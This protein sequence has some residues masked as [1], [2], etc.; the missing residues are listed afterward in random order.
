MIE[1]QLPLKTPP[2]TA[3][4]ARGF[5]LIELMIAVAVLSILV[6]VALPTFNDSIRKG[7]RTEAFTALSQVQQAQERWRANNANYASNAQLTLPVT[8]ASVG[9]P[10]GLGLSST[11]SGE[12][13]GISIANNDATGYEVLATATSSSSQ[14]N[15][16]NCAK[17]RIRVDR[18][19]I[20]Y[21]STTV[22]GTTYDETAGNRCWSR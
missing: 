9:D 17:L 5:S 8:P 7:R 12:R 6:A 21:G 3:D 14:V 20:F 11:S 4:A 18:G 15:D 22:A 19:S 16:G 1:S 2:C 13:Y 10:V